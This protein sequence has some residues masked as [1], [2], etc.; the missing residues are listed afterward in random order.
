MVVTDTV[1]PFVYTCKP[2]STRKMRSRNVH[3]TRIR[4]FAGSHLNITEQ[5]QAAI[6]RDF[7][8]NEV[9]EIVGHKCNASDGELHLRVQWLGFTRDE[10]TWEP[11]RALHEDVP[12]HVRAYT[13]DHRDNEACG[14]FF[15]QHYMC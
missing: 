6:D 1:T 13:H 3:I 8:A 12:E 9:Q 2:M 5:L 4:R 11:A 10:Q 7:P 15:R 14:Q